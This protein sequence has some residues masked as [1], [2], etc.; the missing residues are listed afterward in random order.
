MPGIYKFETKY[1]KDVVRNSLQPATLLLAYIAL[2]DMNS[3]T[4]VVEVFYILFKNKHLQNMTWWLL[5]L[6]VNSEI[7]NV[8]KT[9][10]GRPKVFCKK[11]ALKNFEKITGKHLC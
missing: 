11:S 7:L 10:S 9:R 3:F 6:F 4:G 5:P 1:F 8:E 2:L